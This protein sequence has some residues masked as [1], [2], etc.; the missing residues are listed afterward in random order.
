MGTSRRVG[1]VATACAVVA[2]GLTMNGA[3]AAPPSTWSYDTG[4]GLVFTIS[5]TTGDI[6]SLAHHGVELTA[7]G[8]AA[9][10]VNSGW[11]SA[12][13]TRRDL[14]TTVVFT[15]SHEG[16]TQYYVARR[17]DNTIYLATRV[18]VRTDPLRFIARLDPA[19]LPTSPEATRTAGTVA[20]VEG[21][22]VFRFP[23]SRTASKF[24]SSQRLITQRPFGASGPAH[25]VFI[26]PGRQELSAG[27]PFF[28]DHEVNDTGDAINLTQVMYSSHY[29]TE[30]E[31]LGVH[32]PY[33]LAVTDGGQPAVHSTD[34]M[35]DYVPDLPG[36]GARG[37]VTG[38]ASGTWRGLG[39]TVTLSGP[40]G[41]YWAKVYRGSFLIKKV[42]PGT[43]TATLHAGE[44]AVGTPGTVTVTAGGTSTLWLTGDVPAPG[45]IA[46]VGTIDGTPQG[47]GNADKIET[48]HPSDSR[49]G[50]W[51]LS[52]F[53]AGDPASRFPMAQFKA[54]NPTIPL[55]FELSSVPSRGVTV[56][57]A[58]T[59]SFAGGRPRIAIGSWTSPLAASPAPVNLKSRGVT[60][61]TWRGVNRTY[62]FA[63]PASALRTGD[64]T[65]TISPVSGSSGMGFLSPNYVFDAVSIDPA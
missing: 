18:D 60:R 9:G 20:A 49:M 15:A 32:G 58:T 2:G 37:T 51:T 29:Q 6:T 11:R 4:A 1:V 63:V 59:G 13:V 24:Y 12:T 28:R 26:L 14:G 46:Q 40:V 55:T 23:D 56:R 48:M 61:G 21:S 47:F 44:L 62:W 43:Y 36:A 53:R 50:P 8:R 57:I 7:R 42:R 35:S 27:G 52:S 19:H 25:G 65:M 3:T 54:V 41:Q 31:R 22:D 17:G 38:S 33:A 45:T 34:W 10:Q 39:G 64:N 5:R 30:D 16:V